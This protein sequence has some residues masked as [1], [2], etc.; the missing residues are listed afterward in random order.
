MGTVIVQ[1]LYFL[2]SMVAHQLPYLE[3]PVENIEFLA[4]SASHGYLPINTEDI[5][6]VSSML[7]HQY[8]E[9][10]YIDTSVEEYDNEDEESE[11]ISSF[12]SHQLPVSGVSNE[13]NKLI[14][15]YSEN[16][17]I[18][19]QININTDE[20]KICNSENE[21]RLPISDKYITPKSNDSWIAGYKVE[22]TENK[23]ITSLVSHQ[24]PGS[25]HATNEN[26]EFLITSVSHSITADELPYS[27]TLDSEK[28]ML[29]HHVDDE[30]VNEEAMS[31][32][33]SNCDEL[34]IQT[35]IPVSKDKT[36]VNAVKQAENEIINSK[37]KL[38]DYRI[39][40]Y[41]E[42]TD[43]QKENIRHKESPVGMDDTNE[44]DDNV[45]LNSYTSKLTRIQ[46]LQ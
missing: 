25:D 22:D 7:A 16:S 20:D 38:V 39:N 11:H 44:T 8:I 27:T 10:Q 46:K 41:T 12:V 32:L 17:M 9:Q 45:A 15:D 1:D 14:Y 36:E 34:N 31:K 18:V 21:N 5:C 29:V 23:L 3:P 40:S 42:G 30:T 6:I 33:S 37:E 4:S 43:K 2:P 26:T 19:H 24:L 13:H 28:S 35:N